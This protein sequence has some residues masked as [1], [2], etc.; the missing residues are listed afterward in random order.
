MTPSLPFA[1][2]A[3]IFT[4]FLAIQAS[5]NYETLVGNGI[6]FTIEPALRL[7]PGGK[8]GD[9]YRRALAR[10]S[11]YFNAHPYMAALAVGALA[12]AEL[13]GEDPARIERFR[14]ALCGPL[15]ATGDRL[16]WAAWLPMSMMLGLLA[17]GAGWGPL[18][19]VLTFLVTYNTGHLGLRLW[20][21][22]VGYRQG[23]QVAR[24]L[25]IPLFRAGPQWVSR[26]GSLL[27]GLAIPLALAR[28]FDGSAVPR[29]DGPWFLAVL[30]VVGV[31]GAA[32]TRLHGR[33]DVWKWALGV[34]A[35][36]ALASMVLAWSNA[37]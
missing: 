1:T 7:L 26:A 12:R 37:R 31:G 20:G 5:W 29:I 4:R 8:D 23:L 13:D 17:F 3:E 14:T 21:L 25:G 34:L 33:Y 19:T 28:L 15:G 36:V 22:S 35:L 32:V 11:Q 9:A 16:V 2:R 18:A 6:G 30:G 24:A 10:Q 27:A